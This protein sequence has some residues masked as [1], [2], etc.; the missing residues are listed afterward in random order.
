[1]VLDAISCLQPVKWRGWWHLGPQLS[2]SLHELGLQWQAWPEY[3]AARPA[4][5]PSYLARGFGD[6]Q[7]RSTL[8]RTGSLPP[9]QHVLITALVP[10]DTEISV[11]SCPV[12]G[13]LELPDLGRIHWRWPRSV[14][15]QHRSHS[16]ALPVPRVCC[17]G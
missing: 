12:E 13:S 1:M 2:P 16:A 4:A 5:Q 8:Q 6:R 15:T 10:R 7:P 11:D 14:T 3:S 9:G 17:Q